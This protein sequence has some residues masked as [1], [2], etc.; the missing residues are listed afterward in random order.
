M[1]ALADL[2]PVAAQAL[3]NRGIT[4][5]EEARA[6]LAHDPGD[7]DPFR[8]AGMHEAVERLRRALRGRE[9]VTV[10]GDFD[11]DGVTATALLVEVL[12]A[13]GGDVRAYIPH[14]E[15]DGYG[16]RPEAIKRLAAQGTRLVV[17]V[18]CGIRAAEEV[19]AAAREGMDVIVTDHHALP[20]DLPRAAA[21]VNPRRPDCTYGFREFAA[22]GLAFKLAQ[23]LLREGPRSGAAPA[24]SDLLDLV[25]LGTV[26]DVVPMLGENRVLVHRGLAELRAARRPGVLALCEVSSVDPADVTARGISFSLAPRINAAGRMDDADAALALLLA[27]DAAAARRKADVL[28]IRNRARRNATDRALSAANA[29]LADR[30]DE[31][32]LMYA[33]GD[34][35]LGV[36]GLVAGRLAERHCRPVAVLKVD[37]DR[38]RGSARSIPGF[39]L[40]A[41]LEEVRGLLVRF[42]GHAR[43][44]GFTVRTA[45]LAE[46]EARL[47]ELAADALTGRDLRPLLQID[48]EVQLADLD[49]PLHAALEGLAPFG[50]G[51]P[52]PLLV[53]RDVPVTGAR[54]VGV[55][56]L[57]FVV[58]GGPGVG[59]LDAIAFR[60][61]DR[62]PALAAV[63]R[64]D[65]VFHLQVNEW[66]GVRRLEMRVEDL[67]TP[68]P[69]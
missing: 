48:A 21:I 11:A 1:R 68:E 62:L 54:A 16:M 10:Y 17:T 52:E 55:N 33:D 26:A 42:G 5:E 69:A 32:F 23:A 22:V 12:R 65:V 39:D 61:A 37:E 9:P 44:A 64:A 24:E 40:V 27:P 31:P 8:L 59:S 43:A 34:V 15:R 45:D 18:D 66:R 38:A 50:E 41:A 58:E 46:L 67:A 4:E 20:A 51:N 6:F 7:D 25:A 2:H 19:A 13:L 53:V 3:A 30:A 47:R 28:E 14:R 60:Q 49:W 56:H 57:K 29:H 63:E 35:A 36:A